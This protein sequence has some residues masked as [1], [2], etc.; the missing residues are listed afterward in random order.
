MKYEHSA[1]A[2]L[3]T[4]RRGIPLFVLVMEKSGYCG[5][6]KGHLEGD[7]TE[8]QAAL[9]EIFEETGIKAQLST[10]FKIT[11]EYM[12]ARRIKKRVTYFSAF[13]KNQTPS[14]ASG[15]VRAVYLLPFEKAM[16]KLS[17]DSSKN[18]LR[19]FSEYFNKKYVPH[20]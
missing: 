2:V 6:P 16:E 17:F 5:F 13:F 11:D 18:I 3:Y 4:I 20:L 19:C 1:G 14:D 7:E 8:E 15:E 12:K 9:R 10:D